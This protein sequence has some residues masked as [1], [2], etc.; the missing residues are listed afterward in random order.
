LPLSFLGVRARKV[1]KKK[2]K[3]KKKRWRLNLEGV[4]FKQLALI[5]FLFFVIG[6]DKRVFLLDKGLARALRLGK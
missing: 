5:E 6:E 1:V 3:K 4:S 2:K